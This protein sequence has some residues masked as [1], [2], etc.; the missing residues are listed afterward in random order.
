MQFA[1]NNSSPHL[2]GPQSVT[3]V[4]G[5]VL[6]ALVPG[7]LAMLWYLRLGRTDQ[8]GDRDRHRGCRRGRGAAPA[9]ARGGHHAD[10]SERGRH[11]LAAGPRPAAAAA[12][13]ADGTGQ[14]LRD[15]HRQAAIRRHRPQPVQPGHGRLRPAAGVF[16]GD[17]DALAAARGGQRRRA[18]AGR[19]AAYHLQRDAAARARPGTRSPVPPRSTRCAPSCR[20]TA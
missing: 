18:L 19:L 1:S 6:L 3:R 20:R 4:M 12:L 16:P 7:T 11:R 15:H 5:L 17:H 2:S 8:P 9:R 13:V 10:R 14:R